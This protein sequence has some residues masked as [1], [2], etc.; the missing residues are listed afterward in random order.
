MLP[1]HCYF[2]ER[3]GLHSHYLM[4]RDA[5]WSFQ[6]FW[7][8]LPKLKLDTTGYKIFNVFPSLYFVLFRNH[9]FLGNFAPR[10]VER[11]TIETYIFEWAALPLSDAELEQ[12]T[13]GY[14]IVDED[15]AVAEGMQRSTQRP[16]HTGLLGGLEQRIAWFQDSCGRVMMEELAP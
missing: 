1:R 2:Y 6:Y 4:R 3:E 14:K 9:F 13:R 11:T 12:L 5:D 15:Q 7:D 8:D 16:E 10:T